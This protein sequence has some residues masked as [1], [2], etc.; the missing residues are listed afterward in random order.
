LCEWSDKKLN[1]GM[2]RQS[3]NENDLRRHNKTNVIKTLKR[4]QNRQLH[5]GFQ[6]W[7]YNTKEL[8]NV[9]L[10]ERRRLELEKYMQRVEDI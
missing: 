2:R 7:L 1:N 3:D 9:T 10:R 4:L 5:S 8:K 6:T